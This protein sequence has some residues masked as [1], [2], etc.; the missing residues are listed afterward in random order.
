M[1]KLLLSLLA[2]CALQL[3]NPAEARVDIQHW[4]TPTGSKVYFVA[5]PTLPMLDVQIDFSAGA[6][7]EADPRRAGLAELTNELLTSGAQ[8]LDEEQIAERLVDLGA[9]LRNSADDDRA[10]LSLRTLSS[11]AER[12][13]AIELMHA[14]LATPTFPV[15]A[16]EREK[17]RNI[18]AIQ[19]AD[20]KPDALAAKRFAETIYPGHPYGVQ[21]TVASVSSITRDDLERF[22]RTHYGARR[23][24]ISIV[25]AVSRA[26]AES[27]AARISEGLPAAEAEQPL[28]AVR[29]P[30]ATTV[31]VAHPAAQSHIYLGLPAIKRGDP[32]FFPLLV[33]N[34]SLGGGGFVSRLM[35]EVRE[36]RGYAYSVYSYFAP[37][38]L[39][40]PFQIGLQTKRA[41][42][43]EALKVVHATLDAFL[44]QGP[45]ASELKAAKQN[46]VDGQALRLDSNAKILGSVALIGFYGLPLDYL[47]QFPLRVDAVTAEQ[48][49]AAF[50][51]HVKRENM[52]TVIV[53]G[54]TEAP[55]AAK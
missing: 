11:P 22:W 47:E 7:Y 40:G 4:T 16:L 26:E 45:S 9:R 8:G 48:V 42:A 43:A 23:A 53:A 24:V 54:D 32:D 46:L 10:S 39:E 41:Q 2:L 38:K 35:Q 20:T 25:G 21:A 15:A 50:A 49:R 55:A 37:G 30:R 31:T 33:G 1:K 18:A 17:A 12:Q 44:R 27:I 19:E 6:A 14:M 52:V 36:K 3:A 28:P 5:S 29:L 51:R 34:Y 13:G